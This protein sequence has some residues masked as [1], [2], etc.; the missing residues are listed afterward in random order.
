M[1]GEAEICA[2]AGDAARAILAARHVQ[3]DVCLVG[4][5]LPGGALVAVRGMVYEAPGAAVV[6]MANDQDVDDLLSAVRAGAVGYVSG[7][8]N[9]HQLRRVVRAVLAR[10]A[11]VPRSMVREL[12]LEL[13]GA[14]R[15]ATE[16]VT[17]REAEVLGMLRR[18][19]STAQ[20]ARRLEISPVTVR[21]HISHIRHKLGVKDRDAL[22]AQGRDTAPQ[23]FSRRLTAIP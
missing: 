1:Q 5:D 23:S 2:E 10:E 9:G 21:R 6:V 4:W 15:L 22:L 13:R 8:I 18:G 11:A 14:A 19:Q 12:L 17:G 7:D 3:P 20:I 16:G